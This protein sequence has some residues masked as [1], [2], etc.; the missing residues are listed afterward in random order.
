MYQDQDEEDDEDSDEDDSD[1]EDSENSEDNNVNG[2]SDN[3]NNTTNNN[4]SSSANGIQSS[5][6]HTTSIN[7]P[8]LITHAKC[9]SEDILCA[10]KRYGVN[11]TE[12]VKSAANIQLGSEDQD[13]EFRGQLGKLIYNL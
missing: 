9:L 10:W 13:D 11:S 7:D 4:N 2:I 12:S 6:I 5:I 8:V 3:E 1:D